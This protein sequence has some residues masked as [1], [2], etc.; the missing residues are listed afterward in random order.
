MVRDSTVATSVLRQE[1]DDAKVRAQV[2]GSSSGVPPTVSLLADLTKAFPPPDKITV[3]VTEL[4][5]TPTA[6]TFTAETD[7]YASADAVEASLQ[8]SERFKSAAKGQERQ[9]RERVSFPVT[10]P[11]GD[12]GAPTE[13]AG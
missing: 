9:S 4:T 1:M 5:I 7:S 12:G 3:D 2:L 8:A 11:L 10:I 13:E 6:V